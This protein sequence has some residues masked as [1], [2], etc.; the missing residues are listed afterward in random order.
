MPRGPLT[1]RCRRPAGSRTCSSVDSCCSA[2]A[3]A[4]SGSGKAP[5]DMSHS[6]RRPVVALLAGASAVVILV[7]PA[8][9]RTRR[10]TGTGP[11]GMPR[12]GSSSWGFAGSGPSY[13]PSDGAVEGWRFAVSQGTT[14]APKPRTDPAK[15]YTRCLQGAGRRPAAKARRRR[16]RLR[17]RCGRTVRR[18]R[19]HGGVVATCIQIPKNGSGLDVLRAPRCPVR[20]KA[21][22]I[23]GLNGYPKTECAP[24]VTSSPSPTP[25]HSASRTSSPTPTADAY[26]LGRRT[27]STSSP[28]Q[29]SER[30]SSS[31]AS[32]SASRQPSH[33]PRRRDL[34]APS[35][36]TSRSA[37]VPLAQRPSQR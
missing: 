14:S 36:G 1:R 9:P 30:P 17:H 21:G 23:C 7:L 19:H 5:P 27:P 18:E 24:A 35:L 26:F 31:S 4:C 32:K 29:A 28:V 20:E 12:P 3:R 8:R 16:A 25:P 13:R 11:T 2:P 10:R 15:A 6:V 33:R 37:R 22:L 34:V